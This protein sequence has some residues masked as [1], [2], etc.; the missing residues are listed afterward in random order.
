MS[1]NVFV[2]SFSNEGFE[3]IVNLTEIDQAAIMSKLAGKQ[4][5]T[6]VSS[7]LNMMSI[8]A[9]YNGERQM[10]VWLLKLSDD[11]TEE[12]LTAWAAESPQEVADL[13]RANGEAVYGAHYHKTSKVIS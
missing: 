5:T 8:R 13:A 12:E 2:F 11:F 9:R 7:I 3:S 1:G 4:A 10:E 6:S